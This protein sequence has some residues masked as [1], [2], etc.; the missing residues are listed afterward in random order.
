MVVHV[1]ELRTNA[2]TQPLGIDTKQP[3]FAWKLVA[4]EQNVAQTAYAIQVSASAQFDE[5]LIWDS[6]RVESLAQLA[7]SQHWCPRAQ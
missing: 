3:A 6:G 5:G 4:T 7:P 1:N 2:R